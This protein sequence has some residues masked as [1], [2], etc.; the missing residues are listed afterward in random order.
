MT[1]PFETL[2]FGSLVVAL[3]LSFMPKRYFGRWAFWASGLVFA[4][5]VA[6]STFGAPRWQLVPG[7][8]LALVL[9]FVT[10]WRLE[11]PKTPNWRRRSVFGAYILV[12]SLVAVTAFLAPA[13][14]PMFVAP[15]PSGSYKVGVVDIY[16]PDPVRGEEMTVSP[17]DRRE[18]MIHAWYPSD[19]PSDAEP[20]ALQRDPAAIHAILGRAVPVPEFVFSHLEKIPGHSFAGTPIAK[21]G[22]DAGVFPVVVF[23]HGNSSVASQNAPLMEELASHGYIVFSIAHPYQGGWVRYPDGRTVGYQDGW[24]GDIDTSPEAIKRV[25]DQLNAIVMAQT[26]ADYRALVA[27]YI[28]EYPGLNSGLNIWMQDT[29]LL[30]DTLANGGQSFHAFENHMDLERIGI[31]GMSYG[32]ATA[33]LFCVKDPRCKAGIN[34]DG[35]QYGEHNMTMQLEVPFMLMNADRRLPEIADRGP[36]PFEINDFVYHQ[37]KAPIYSVSVANTTHGDYGDF[38]LMTRVGAWVG[39]LGSIDA[40]RMSS[41][42]NDYVRSFF[43][44]HLKGKSAPLLDSA[45]GGYAEILEFVHRNVDEGTIVSE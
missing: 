40:L 2:V 14:F 13:A 24:Y 15:A 9:P 37:A 5:F 16:L 19:V 26:E 28:A 31:F 32:G 39:A 25:T 21:A 36:V 18:L 6:V 45:N 42:M 34:M 27:Q 4:G 43:D 1:G 20:A 7:A 10:L 17:H 8:F 11:Y 22:P 29:D 33:G 44:R 3:I 12:S 35:L 23:S 41:I 38:G 30:L